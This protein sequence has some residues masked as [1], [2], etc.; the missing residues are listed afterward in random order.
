[1][2]SLPGGSR[3]KR[4][5]KR[6]SRKSK[7]SGLSQEDLDFLSR[8]TKYDEDEIKEWYRGFKVNIYYF[9]ETQADL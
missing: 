9:V 1:M 2:S 3:L 7:A 8:N 5:K 6:K 4:S